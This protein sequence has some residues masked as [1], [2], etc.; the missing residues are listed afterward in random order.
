MFPSSAPLRSLPTL[1]AMWA[2]LAVDELV[3]NGPS[4]PHTE[5]SGVVLCHLS[6]IAAAD[7]AP[8]QDPHR[9]VSPCQSSSEAR[10]AALSFV[11]M[12]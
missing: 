5:N 11:I 3:R 2:A 1:N 9:G 7:G 6:F 10:P 12:R 8:H 4:V